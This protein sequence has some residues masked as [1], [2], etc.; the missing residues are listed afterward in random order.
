[1][2]EDVGPLLKVLRDHRV[3]AVVI[4]GIAAVALGVPCVTKDVDICYDP[5]PE[6]TARLVT[7]LRAVN[8]RL[9][10]AR[11]SDEEAQALPFSLDERS[12]KDA[13]MLTLQTD[14]G[15]LDLVQVLPGIGGYQEVRAAA[16]EVEAFGVSVPVLDL[17]GLIANK[18]ATARPKDL[19]TLPL[20]EATLRE[21]QLREG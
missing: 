5:Q 1:M 3:D 18:T 11:M 7:A 17:P 14:V 20:L 13:E 16:V 4:G 15:A 9:R 6:N 12:L 10:V 8:A 2:S 21:R 19:V